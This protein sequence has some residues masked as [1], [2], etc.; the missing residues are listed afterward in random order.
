M[1]IAKKVGQRANPSEGV[2]TEIF[3]AA[4]KP[5]QR[6]IRRGRQ[7]DKE[8]TVTCEPRQRLGHR[9]EGERAFKPIWQFNARRGFARSLPD[10]R[11]LM[12][13][14]F[15][16]FPHGAIGK[17]ADALPTE[18]FDGGRRAERER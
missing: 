16:D 5:I 1:E 18:P 10:T 11:R 4:Q 14:D 8:V 2:K 17:T 3:A 13:G 7:D 12:S 6:R 9:V 15:D